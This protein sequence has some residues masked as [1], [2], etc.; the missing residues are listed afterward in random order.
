MVFNVGRRDQ[1][2]PQSLACS[3]DILVSGYDDGNMRCYNMV[4]GG[5]LWKMENVHAGGVT[6]VKLASNMRFMVTSG[7]GGELRLWEMKTKSMIAHLKDHTNR[8]NDLQLFPNDQFAISVARDRCVL[9][10]D[11]HAEKRLTL[12]RERHGGINAL[13]LCSDQTTVITAG[14][15]KTLTTWDLR[16]SNPVH[17]L[18]TSDEIMALTIPKAVGAPNLVASGGYDR[19]VR[20]WDVRNT[21]EPIREV[22]MCRGHTGV[23]KSLAFSHDYKQLISVAEDGC[24]FVWNVYADAQDAKAL[25]TG[26]VTPGAKLAEGLTYGQGLI[27]QIENRI[28]A[29][30]FPGVDKD[31]IPARQISSLA[32]MLTQDVNE[33]ITGGMGLNEAIDRA[34]KIAESQGALS[35]GKIQER[36]FMFDKKIPPRADASK[37]T[38]R[39]FSMKALLAANKGSTEE[40]VRAAV[41]AR[42]NSTLID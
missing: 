5:E 27:P 6:N 37:Y 40:E 32:S 15:E 1:G 20:L 9:T 23:V 25:G 39:T 33:M 29:E 8:V 26:N 41:N 11:L 13:A 2:T 7:Q 36:R 18:E 28:T 30:Y 17:T 3:S 22:K 10:W 16:Q 35:K 12:H 4:T 42:P 24:L 21:N 34:M 19:C 38:E 14:Q 31:T